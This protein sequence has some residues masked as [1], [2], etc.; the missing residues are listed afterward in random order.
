MGYLETVEGRQQE[1]LHQS[2]VVPKKS[3]TFPWRWVADM[4]GVNSQT[5][6]V[7]YPLPKIEDI[8]IKQGANQIYTIIDLKQAFHQQ[9][10][11]P[12]SRPYTCTYTPLGIYQWKVNVMGLMNASQ[13]FQQMMDNLLEPVSDV[14]NTFV[15]DV[16]I[17]TRVEDGEDLLDKHYADVWLQGFAYVSFNIMSNMLWHRIPLHFR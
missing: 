4:R 6:R 9:P 7:N 12:E 14:A 3:A 2:F 13:Q 10:L 8:L 11:H 1:W 15:D 17:G 5:R 16:L